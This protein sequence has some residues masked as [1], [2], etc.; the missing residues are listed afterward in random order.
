[1]LENIKYHLMSFNFKMWAIH[2]VWISY[3]CSVVNLLSTVS[4][5]SLTEWPVV[6]YRT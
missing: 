6:Q 4:S 2:T 1:V 3:E 5:Q